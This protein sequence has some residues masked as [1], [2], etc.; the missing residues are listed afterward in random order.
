MRESAAIVAI[1]M[2]VLVLFRPTKSAGVAPAVV[3]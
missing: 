3:D 2:S 1:V